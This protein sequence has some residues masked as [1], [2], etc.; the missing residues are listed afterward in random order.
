M[1]TPTAALKRAFPL[2]LPVMAGY[3]FLGIT[4]GV[5]MVSKG[6]PSFLPQATRL[7]R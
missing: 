3:V 5:L 7:L 1:N 6:M 4:Y 2:T